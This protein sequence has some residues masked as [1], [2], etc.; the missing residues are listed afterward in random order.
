MGRKELVTARMHESGHYF[1]C[2]RCSLSFPHP[3]RPESFYLIGHGFCWYCA[4]YVPLEGGDENGVAE[5][6]EDGE[7]YILLRGAGT[8]GERMSVSQCIR[9]QFARKRDDERTKKVAWDLLARC[10]SWEVY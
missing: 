7:I 10:P 2:P 3:T 5:M 1:F 4:R 6:G 8:E 9:A